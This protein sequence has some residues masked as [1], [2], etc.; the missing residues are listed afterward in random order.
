MK[1][2]APVRLRRP[3]S[4]FIAA[5]LLFCLSGCVADDEVDKATTEFVQSSTALTQTYQ[6]F[7]NN[8]NA[9][10]AEN[11]IDGQVYA[12][13]EITSI[14][15]DHSAIITPE[16]ITLR[17]SALK[18]L[19]GYTTALASLAANKPTIQIQ[20][21]A[22]KADSSLKTLTKDATGVFD[23]PAKGAK[24][25]DYASPISD[26]VSAISDVLKLIE[27]HRAASAIRA[28]IEKND[29]KITPLYK[30][31]E[32]ES[33]Y[34][35]DRQTQT[36]TQMGPVLFSIYEKARKNPDT[37]G[38]LQVGD[39]IK[40]YEKDSAALNASDPTKAINAFERSHVALV[41]L[42]TAKPAHK[43]ES[44]AALIAEIKSFAAEVKSP[45]K[46]STSASDA[47]SN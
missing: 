8:A 47:K 15:L 23:K 29:A 38:L 25:A 20:T 43:K 16:E 1:P 2:S 6:N 24:T 46:S 42:I 32:Q 3:I 18:A 14:G 41:K 44:L 34:Y 10:E 5:T 35:F 36:T 28:S 37:V 13:D 31:I 39:R 7:L 21:D 30:V 12:G 9:V 33:A 11:Y 17:T 27:D 4:M 22:A 19:T 45:S 40:Q 26:A